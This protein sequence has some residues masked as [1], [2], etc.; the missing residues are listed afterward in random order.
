[1]F[2]LVAYIFIYGVTGLEHGLLDWFFFAAQLTISLKFDLKPSFCE[3]VSRTN[4]SPV[5][6]KYEGHLTSAV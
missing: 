2:Q 4:V 1:M 5:I 6:G 3:N